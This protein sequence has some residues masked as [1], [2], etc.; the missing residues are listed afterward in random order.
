MNAVGWWTRNLR[1]SRTQAR[2]STDVSPSL[3]PAQITSLGVLLVA[4]QLP[5]A[6]HL[7]IW[8]ALF[9]F[10]LVVLR[11]V[12][13]RRDRARPLATPARIPSWAL[14]L[15]ALAIAFAIRKSYGYFIGRD[16]CV[17]FLFVL[18]GIKFL[19]VRTLRDGTLLVCLAIFLLITPFFYDQSL[20]AGLAALPAVL[21][22]G[23][24]L[25]SL[26]HDATLPSPPA[27]SRAAWRRTAAMLAQGLPIAAALFL[28]FPRLASPLWGLPA[29]RAAATG[30]S[31]RM[32]PGS[33]SELA[34]NDAVAFRVDF[35]GA[36][37]PPRARYWRGPVLSL[38][39][40]RE[41][42]ALSPTPGGRLAPSDGTALRYTITL[43]PNDHPWLFALD[44]PSSMPQ[45][46]SDV[47][48]PA[49]AGGVAGYSREQ[50]LL[51]RAP[52]TQP[53]RYMVESTLGDS[54][55]VPSTRDALLNS[56]APAGNPRTVEFA[57]SLRAANPDERRFVGA[58]LQWFRDEAFF[59][60]LAPPL[61]EE[62]PVDG[63]LFDSRRG[64][65]EHYASAFVVML[66]AAGIPARVVTGYQGGE[67]NP[68]G[69]YM[70][71]RQSDAHAWAEAIID[72]RWQR[73]DPTAAVAPSRVERGLFGSVAASEPVPFFARD[74]SGF[75]KEV[76]LALDAFN[77]QWRRNVIQFN[78]DRQR[79]LWREWKL[80]RFEPSQ[81]AVGASIALLVWAGGVFAWFAARRKRQERALTLWNDVCRR[82]ARAG[83]P[84]MNYEGPIAF[85]GRAASRWP[86]FDI[87][88]RAIGESF[89]ALRYGVERRDSERL[90]LIATL[91]RAIDVLP[92]PRSLRAM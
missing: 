2:A 47:G 18:V 48:A 22:A 28:L 10:A 17:A 50:Q 44:F 62:D 87:A 8:V 27:P 90:A 32:A 41:W 30:L 4:A 31:D 26:A 13:L 81:V 67:I 92:A 42:R 51:M 78:R 64:F 60:T 39:N 73:F 1:T 55:A 57:R 23:A 52:V 71:V 37:P 86:Q 33:I 11:F 65:C 43:E 3:T 66:R 34:L 70:I 84:R 25:E 77:H 36:P 76:Q 88:F 20:L 46:D 56:R 79:A 29:D 74:D 91:E 82:L 5:Q 75:L 38:F 35:D 85:A 12:L 61:L 49:G 21:A 83:L 40:G 16:P 45:I 72:G 53:L 6:V 80:D 9:G 63:F 58:V 24:A 19:E 68:R 59:Y 14:A 69:G 54:Y 7:P 89:A 15:F